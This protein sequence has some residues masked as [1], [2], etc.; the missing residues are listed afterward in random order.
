MSE[1]L[2]FKSSLSKEQIRENH[3]TTQTLLDASFMHGQHDEFKEHMENNPVHHN[4]DGS[5]ADGIELVMS[6]KRTLSDVAPT[7]EILLQ[8]GAKLAHD[9]LIMA[10]RITP[11]HVICRST[12]D[13]QE[14]LE[15]MIKEL[16]RSLLNVKA[17]DECTALMYAVSNA[18]IKC[19]ESLIASGADVNLINDKPNVTYRTTGVLGPLIDSI[20]LLR[21]NSPHSYNTMMG[22]FDLLL[23]SGADV[24]KPCY[25]DQ[26]TPIL[27]AA[28]M[29]NVN[30]VKKLIQ[31]GAQVNYTDRTG[32]TVWALA[33][34][35]GSVDLLKFLIEDN[36]IEM[37][38]IDRYGFS[39]LFWAVSSGNIEAV[40][41]LLNQGVTMTSFVPQECVE[42]CKNCGTNVSCHY[43]HAPVRTD[44]YVR[45][46]IVDMLDVVR[47]MDEHGCQLGKSPEILSIAIHTKSVNVVEY[48]LYKYKYPLNY[49]YIDKYNDNKLNSGHQ[50]FLSKACENQLVEIVK[51]L[52]EHGADPNKKYCAEKCPPVINVA[53]YQRR[54]K[55]LAS[56]I[57]AGVNVNTRSH[58]SGRFCTSGPADIGVVLPFEAAVYKN[59][60]CAAEILL[61]AGCSRGIHCLNN[62]CAPKAKIEPEM[63]ELLKEW[64]VH[65]NNVLPLQ[66]RC[67]MVILNHLCPQADK[68]IKELPLPSQ[69]IKY[70]NIPELDD[71]LEKHLSVN[72]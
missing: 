45:A 48:L 28:A 31:K 59:H 69:I 23:D 39:I 24:N 60:I 53:I 35:A 18:N 29:G 36:G 47:L 65:K 37:N 71:I 14:L 42:A 40:R 62:I 19:V 58:Y 50:T 56:F 67:R 15:L 49:G 52:L 43:N 1:E 72:H 44:P 21:P 12:G 66:Q 46:I 25:R 11:Y 16:G 2:Q 3:S 54:V 27:Y 64:D 70:L 34:R 22:I 33:A 55:H 38:S 68:K 51:L 57:R 10:G 61:V 7:L 6:K 32:Q 17:G 5:L 4:L 41:Y 9:Y 20:K 63:Q 26:R 13:H 30:C 8:N